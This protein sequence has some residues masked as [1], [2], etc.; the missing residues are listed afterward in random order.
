M[1]KNISCVNCGN[2]GHVVKDCE[3]A[4]IS[5]GII[6]FKVVN[7]KESEL[8]DKNEYLSNL[9]SNELKDTELKDTELK[10]NV[11]D[12]YPKLKFLLIQR[13]DTIGYVDFV[14][15]KYTLDTLK[16]CLNEMTISERENVLT[17]TFQEIWD[18]LWVNKKSS[19]FLKEYDNAFKKYSQLDIP[20]L[21]NETSSDYNFQEF[22][23]AKGR[24]NMRESDITCAKREFLEETGYNDNEYDFLYKF[25]II[26][27]TF[28]GT[29]NVDYK[30][31]YY[32]VKMKDSAHIPTVDKNNT[33]Q[34][35]E[36][37]NIGWFTYDESLL[38]FRPYDME[39]KNILKEIYESLMRMNFRFNYY[40][41]K[42]NDLKIPIKYNNVNYFNRN[43]HKRND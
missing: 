1:F 2:M 39:K 6:A 10:D 16:I 11:M 8:N 5:Y 34:I 40:N 22:S 18:C 37:R 15:G 31:V 35:G 24:R 38:L 3:D 25:P 21:L 30:H 33:L 43:F 32:V 29:N 19:L 13:K 4:I 28:T 7:D 27:E 12:E 9:I 17:K 41:K 20:K 26:E 36:V 14:R 42:K 23:F